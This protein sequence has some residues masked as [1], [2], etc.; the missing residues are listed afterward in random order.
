MTSKDDMDFKLG[1]VLYCAICIATII[2]LVA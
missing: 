1:V 2:L